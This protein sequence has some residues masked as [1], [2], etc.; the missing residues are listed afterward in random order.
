MLKATS[1]EPDMSSQRTCPRPQGH[2]LLHDWPGIPLAGIEG[3]GSRS[4]NQI[5]HS[6]QLLTHPPAT[7]GQKPRAPGT[8][9]FWKLKPLL[10]AL[11]LCWSH[12]FEY[13]TPPPPRNQGCHISFLAQA[14]CLE[15]LSDRQE[16]N[17]C[18]LCLGNAVPI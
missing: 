12:P 13:F 18:S 8:S 11:I 2:L 1:W 15:Q 14:L 5:S 3:G 4:S 16:S 17:R 6:T 7:A 9:W 10:P